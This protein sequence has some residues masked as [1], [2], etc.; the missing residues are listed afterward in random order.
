MKPLLIVVTPWLVFIGAHLGMS[1]SRLREKITAR[2]G[3]FAFTLIYLFVTILTLGTV[4]FALAFFGHE[5]PAGFQVSDQ[6][7]LTVLRAVSVFGAFLL[8]AGLISYPTSAIAILAQRMKNPDLKTALPKPTGIARITRHPFFV[9]LAFVST[10]HV[11]LASTLA[12][13]VSFACLAFLSLVG[14]YLQDKKLQKRWAAT[15]EVFIERSSVLPFQRLAEQDSRLTARD[16]PMLLIALLVASFL[17]GALHDI[18]TVGNGATFLG[19]ILV[20]GT[21]GVVTGI[22]KSA[23]KNR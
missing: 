20:Y 6:T 11:F 15:Y 4:I 3:R 17:F 12:I 14:I 19:F 8:V 22:L 9:G 18:W 10:S 2:Y 16:I 21:I 1:S 5:G 7:W 13:A 23:A